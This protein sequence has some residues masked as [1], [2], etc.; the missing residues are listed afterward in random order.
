[1]APKDPMVPF[2]INGSGHAI[3]ISLTGQAYVSQPIE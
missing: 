2:K 3:L 1:M